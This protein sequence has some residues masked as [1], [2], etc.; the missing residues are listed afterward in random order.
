MSVLRRA[1]AADA[2]SY[3][4]M[5]A[6]LLADGRGEVRGLEDLD[7]VE[8][9]AARLVERPTWVVVGTDGEVRGAAGLQ[10]M[11]VARCRHVSSL[12]VAVHPAHQRRGHGRRL[13]ERVLAEAREEGIHRLELNVRADNTRALALY[14]SLGFDQESVRRDFVRLEDHT[15][16]DDLCLVRFLTPTIRG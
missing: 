15:F 13:M 11:R 9:I 14:R 3:R 2:P 10:R 1:T 16:V 4:R 6:V 7:T 8:A 12:F 5:D